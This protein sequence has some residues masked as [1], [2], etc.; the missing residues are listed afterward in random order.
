MLVVGILH[1]FNNKFLGPGIFRASSLSQ[2]IVNVSGTTAPT[3][4]CVSMFFKVTCAVIGGN[5]IIL[6]PAV[7]SSRWK[8]TRKKHSDSTLNTTLHQIGTGEN[9]MFE[10][11]DECIFKLC[12]ESL[13]LRNIRFHDPVVLDEIWETLSIE[14]IALVHCP[15][16][17]LHASSIKA[18]TQIDASK[19]DCKSD[20]VSKEINT[21]MLDFVQQLGGIPHSHT[22]GGPEGNVWDVRPFFESIYHDL[23]IGNR[24]APTD[25]APPPRSHTA[26]EFDMHTDCSFE[27]PPPRY[28]ALYVMQEDQCG[29]GYSTLIDTD[30]INRYMS[31]RSLQTFLTTDFVVSV[32]PEFHKG[33][34]C[35][36]MKLIT[37]DQMLWK[38]RADI[39][40][41][42]L[43]TNDQILALD[44]LDSLLR[45]PSLVLTTMIPTGCLLLLDNMRWFHGRSAIKDQNRWLKRIRFQ[46]SADRA[47][48]ALKRLVSRS[49]S[50]IVT[51]S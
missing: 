49:D 35:L 19:S 18:Q 29:G 10:M 5:G 41:K 25:F 40:K 30:V 8:L 2:P 24:S 32:P 33:V 13:S 48:P 47:P 45:N 21:L 23:R 16:A 3:V 14:G 28:V 4:A 37:A 27:D 17:A 11:P 36:S 31:R 15:W 7:L 34:D 46:P 6:S 1:C 12:D 20:S 50:L 44:E 22:N 42:D 26:D 9:L 39:I 51:A 43:C 38:Y